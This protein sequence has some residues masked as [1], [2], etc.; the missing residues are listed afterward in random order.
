MRWNNEKGLTLLEVSLAL[1]ILLIGV[2][3]ILKSDWVSHR[4]SYERQ[5]RQQ[6]MFFAA[7]ELEALIEGNEGLEAEDPLLRSR[8]PFND[9]EVRVDKQKL[10]TPADSTKPYLEK[11]EVTVTLK[12]S[13]TRVEPARLS[14]YRVV[15]QE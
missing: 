3:F 12:S 14:T 2:G 6:M 7:G 8:P 9:F 11:I 5:L 15:V 10:T 4:L 13:P 1:T